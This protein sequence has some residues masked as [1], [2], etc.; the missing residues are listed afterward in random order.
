MEWLLAFL[1]VLTSPNQSPVRIHVGFHEQTLLSN[2]SLTYNL[3][4]H[5]MILFSHLCSE[6]IRVDYVKSQNFHRYSSICN[7]GAVVVPWQHVRFTSLQLHATKIRFWI[8]PS[9]FCSTQ[10][11]IM[12]A[13]NQLDASAENAIQHFPVCL[14]T[15]SD[16]SR[17]QM[18]ISTR[19]NSSASVHYYSNS[20]SAAKHCADSQYCEF[21]SLHPFFC[22]IT[23]AG[24]EG[25]FSMQ[26]SYRIQA[27]SAAR[28]DRCGVRSLSKLTE[29]GLLFPR[30]G[31][32]DIS[33][34]CTSA[35]EELMNR[36]VS[37]L[38]TV[39][40]TTGVLFVI[41]CMGVVNLFKFIGCGFAARAMAEPNYITLTHATA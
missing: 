15:Q 12:S 35:A 8:I 30:T 1:V 14:F 40:L 4:G 24:P 26:I 38:L 3:T 19:S 41:H 18:T 29:D 5:T 16:A 39:L 21:R 22:L 37:L 31:V 11:L 28:E 23:G 13:D 34:W 9:T 10:T 33:V 36:I 6:K 17:F 27:K 32:G 25:N 7:K 2:Q 20:M